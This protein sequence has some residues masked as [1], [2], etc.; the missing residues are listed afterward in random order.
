MAK[1]YVEDMECDAKFP[2]D[3]TWNSVNNFVFNPDVAFEDLQ[4]LCLGL[5]AKLETAQQ[6]AHPTS[7][8]L[9]DLWSWL[10]L[11]ASSAL[12]H[13]TSPPTRG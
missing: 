6:S 3:Y 12:K 5:A 13:F 4:S 9:R 8:S 10:W 7:G 11:R 1:D 2:L